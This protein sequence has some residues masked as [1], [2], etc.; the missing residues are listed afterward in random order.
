MLQATKAKALVYPFL[1]RSG[2]RKNGNERAV[3]HAGP[4]GLASPGRRAYITANAG[5]G[6]LRRAWSPARQ[7]NAERLRFNWRVLRRRLP[8]GTSENVAIPVGDS[9]ASRREAEPD[10]PGQ[11]RRSLTP[12]GTYAGVRSSVRATA[13]TWPW[14]IRNVRSRYSP[15]DAAGKGMGKAQSRGHRC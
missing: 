9:K 1:P 7:R 11:H 3:H 14:E 6:P 8:A 10:G 12:A 4:K 5:Q 15:T 13:R 2:W